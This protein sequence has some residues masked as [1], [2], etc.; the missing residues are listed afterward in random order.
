MYMLDFSTTRQLGCFALDNRQPRIA[1]S[2]H[3]HPLNSR[4]LA[5]PFQKCLPHRVTIQ[6]A[7]SWVHQKSHSRDTVPSALINELEVRWGAA[8]TRG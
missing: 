8:E 3:H 4:T 2:E 6:R 5:D 7:E 1:P